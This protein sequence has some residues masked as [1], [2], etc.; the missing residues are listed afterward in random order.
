MAQ[1]V[2]KGL[3]QTKAYIEA[4]YSQGDARAKSSRLL[5]T[6]GNIQGRVKELQ[7]QAAIRCE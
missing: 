1:G 4:S 7:K 6:N 3:M 5:A 2:A